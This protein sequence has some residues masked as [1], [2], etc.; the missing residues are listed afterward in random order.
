[1]GLPL[2]GRICSVECIHPLI[3]ID[4]GIHAFIILLIHYKSSYHLLTL[5]ICKII[6]LL[7]FIDPLNQ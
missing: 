7:V 5:F 2:S 4:P 6:G 1:M 3:I